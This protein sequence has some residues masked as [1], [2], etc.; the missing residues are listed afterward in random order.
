MKKKKVRTVSKA[1]KDAW[2]AFSRYIRTRDALKTTGG[3]EYCRCITCNTWKLAIGTKYEQGLQ[4]GHFI[5]GR[6]NDILF[7]EEQVNAQCY[8]CNEGLNGNWTMYYKVMIQRHGQEKVN[9]MINRPYQ[10]IQFKVFQLDEI[11]DK[12]NKK[13]NKLLI[14]A[15]GQND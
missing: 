10:S 3:I 12:Y 5:P 4:A 13:Y 9:E 7:D 1:K 11:R 6:T 15:G 2:D 14:N 8:H